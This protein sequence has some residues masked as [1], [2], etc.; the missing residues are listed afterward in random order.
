MH[1]FCVGYLNLGGVV[2]VCRSLL[3]GGN[4][5]TSS[6]KDIRGL[7]YKASMIYK[8]STN[9]RKNDESNA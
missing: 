8:K 6:L 2:A 9:R 3:E 5:A 7:V 4:Y 1:T